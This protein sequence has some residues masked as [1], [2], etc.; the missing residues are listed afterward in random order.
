M[1]CLSAL[2]IFASLSGC[3]RTPAIEGELKARLNNP[4]YLLVGEHD[5]EW[6]DTAR[7]AQYTLGNFLRVLD[8]PTPQQSSFAIKAIVEEGKHSEAVW[9]TS[10][11]FD[12]KTFYG[13][14]NNDPIHLR[15]V[16]L[17]TKVSVDQ[18]RIRD[19]MYV[20]NGQL[21]GGYS[22]KLLYR[23]LDPIQRKKMEETLW[24]AMN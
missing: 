13:K 11:E 19:W 21:H 7:E 22:L 1:R 24:F 6:D 5:P 12:G 8:S 23:K 20:E 18:A 14:V 9:L 3:Y 15:K 16:F 2:L 4:Y 10:L 17:G